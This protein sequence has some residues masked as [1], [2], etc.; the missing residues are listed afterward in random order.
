[1]RTLRLFLTAGMVLGVTATVTMNS[2]QAGRYYVPSTALCPIAPSTL[3]IYP[4][5]NWEPFFRRHY[6]RYGP[7]YTICAG[8]TPVGNV[9]SVKY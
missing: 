8:V 1:M 3:Y 5:A 9:I 2:A 6:Y 4:A 7:I